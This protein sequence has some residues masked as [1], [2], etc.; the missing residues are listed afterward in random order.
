MPSADFSDAL[1]FIL[2]RMA[3]SGMASMRPAPKRGVGVRKI[4][5]GFPP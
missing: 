4:M 3:E 2:A 1:E 5:F